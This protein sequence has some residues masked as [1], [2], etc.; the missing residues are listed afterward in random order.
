VCDAGRR[1]VFTA[2]WFGKDFQNATRF[3]NQG[4]FSSNVG[5]IQ[6]FSREEFNSIGLENPKEF[7][8]IPRFLGGL[9][10]GLHFL[11]F[12]FEKNRSNLIINIELRR[13]QR[14]KEVSNN[15]SVS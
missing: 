2:P 1:T 14:T 5:V 6:V 10:W 7:S 13:F 3:Q 9:Q 12:F 11:W 8:K 4:T 15:F